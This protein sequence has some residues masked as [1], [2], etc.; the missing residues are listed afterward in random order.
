MISKLDLYKVFCE[1]AKC[2]S[3][4]GA[5][6]NLYM[7]QPAVS[8]SIMQLE[9]ELDVRLFTR[10]SKGVKLTS[11]G[12]LLYEYAGS[13]INLISSGEQKLQDARGLLLGELKIGVGDTISKYFLLPYLEKFHN[14]SPNIK[15][16]I[17]NRTTMELC[18]MLKSGEI[19]IALCNLPIND[20]SIETLKCMEVQDIFVCGEK[21][22]NEISGALSFAELARL[23]LIF[24]DHRSNSRQYVENFMLSRGVRIAPDIEL[25]SHDLLL[26]FAG[27]NLGVACV[28]REFSL[29]YLENKVLYEVAI[30]ERI[31]PR[32][33]GFCF[34][35]G[36]SLSSASNR[37]VETV[38]DK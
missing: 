23:P 28:V 2:Q 33:I 24:L 21:Y 10:T 22:H 11:E 7:T 27:I 32:E 16:K 4:S 6:K 17:I 38:M 37:F 36:L 20:S 9:G 13:A 14:E 18:T 29:E 34:L 35:K 15:L 1:V 26:D 12:Q 19:D 5:A 8:Q 25:G 3:F 30:E 31:L